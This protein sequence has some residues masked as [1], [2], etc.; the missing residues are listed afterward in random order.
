MLNRLFSLKGIVAV[1]KGKTNYIPPPFPPPRR[2]EGWE[3]V[4][5]SPDLLNKISRN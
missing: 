2:G 3:G 5:W 1:I 4:K